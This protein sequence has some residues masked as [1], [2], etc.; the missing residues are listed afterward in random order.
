MSSVDLFE[1]REDVLKISYLSVGLRNKKSSDL[2]LRK[3][4]KC[5]WK[6]LILSLVL[7]AM[8]VNKLLNTDVSRDYL[9][10]AVFISKVT[11]SEAEGIAT[12]QISDNIRCCNKI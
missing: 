8:D 9:G 1:S 11:K 3:L 12:L 4:D 2:F 10:I 7:A 5:L 6:C